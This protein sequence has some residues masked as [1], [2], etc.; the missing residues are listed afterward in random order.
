MERERVDAGTRRHHGPTKLP[1]AGLHRGES[2]KLN[3]LHSIIMM[4]H[5]ESVLEPAMDEEYYYQG[6]DDCRDDIDPGR[7]RMSNSNDITGLLD[8]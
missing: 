6:K 8:L 7:N 4:K 2:D 1:D 5:V 3:H